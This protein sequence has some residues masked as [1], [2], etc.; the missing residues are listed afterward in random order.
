MVDAGGSLVR[1]GSFGRPGNSD[2]QLKT[3][4]ALIAEAT[5]LG[6]IDAMA[7]SASDWQLG[8]DFVRGLIEEHDLPVV[9]ANL[10]CDGA[11]PYPASRIVEVG[12]RR[13]AVI[14]VTDGTIPGCT[15]GPAGPAL[16]AAVD[17]L[18]AVDFTVALLPFT[19]SAPLANV[20]LQAGD[21]LDV[22]LAIDATGR[23][24]AG[25]PQERGSAYSIGTGSRAK[26]LGIAR[27][28]FLTGATGWSFLNEGAPSQKEQLER[29]EEREAQ[30][31]DKAERAKTAAD[32]ATF[33]R[34]AEAYRVR[35]QQLSSRLTSQ[36]KAG[37]NTLTLESRALDRTIAD[38][39]ATA[40][41]VDAAKQAIT[42]EV[43]MPGRSFV[44]R[45]VPSG[46]YAGGETC[47]GCHQGPHAQWSTTGHARAWNGLVNDNRQF[48]DQCW[49]CHVTG[50]N[51]PG[52]PK[53]A[54]DTGPYRDV[55]CE[56]CHGPARKHLQNPELAAA[57]P[58]AK[59]DVS[60][61]T[62]CHDGTQDEGR[63]DV[64]AYWPKVVHGSTP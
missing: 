52:G 49:T 1:P 27:L 61:C 43:A 32:R 39:A 15:T 44:P 23:S 48:D 47:A 11:A 35:R 16:N 57:R 60:V 31:R 37:T 36:A 7:L 14:G 28:S 40:R 59:P 63:F 8:A 51:Q 5:A 26:H 50:A 56:A 18:G 20:F 38:H 30:S 58:V 53:T 62:G 9:A 2:S 29:L 3:K 41:L 6:G 25:R 19:Q 54:V 17:A 4:A 34:Q 21:D 22:D 55:Q 45:V 46:P 42:A 24:L 64:E 13:V 12:A 33:E 10:T